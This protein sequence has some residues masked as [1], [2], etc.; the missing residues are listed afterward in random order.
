[1]YCES[2]CAYGLSYSAGS[3]HAPSV[4][5][6][7]YNIFSR[8]LINGRI[9]EKKSCKQ[10]VGFDFLY[11]L[12]LKHFSF[13]EKLS[14]IWPRKYIGLHVKHPLFLFEFNETWIF[15]T[16]FRKH[17]SIKFRGNPSSGTP[18]C[19]T[20]MDGRTDEQTDTTE[21]IFTF[22]NF[23]NARN[24]NSIPLL[25]LLI[26]NTSFICLRP[27]GTIVLTNLST[28]SSSSVRSCFQASH[29]F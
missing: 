16:V 2:V 15:L 21:L 20:R 13:Q 4:A 27:L 3:E 19:S 22:R 6:P 25:S 11:N 24:K 17:T 10:N 7:P 14:E 18:S 29:I 5:S 26:T 28:F 8:C 1:M 12:R 9:F 23:A